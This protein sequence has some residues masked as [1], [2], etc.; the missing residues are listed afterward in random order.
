MS[1]H[2]AHRYPWFMAIVAASLLVT[3]QGCQPAGP[4]TPDTA[5]GVDAVRAASVA[6]DEAHNAADLSRLIQLYA[7]SAVSMPYN[8]PAL[9]GPRAIEAD[10]REFFDGFQAT[11]KTTIVS[12]EVLGDWAIEHGNYALSVTPKAGGAAVNEI[13]KHIVVRKKIDGAWK[14]HWEIWNTDAAPPQ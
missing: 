2:L 1:N 13:G 4:R 14:V 3:L 9:E 6:W 12:L 11:H 7:D 8:R 10:F 5:G